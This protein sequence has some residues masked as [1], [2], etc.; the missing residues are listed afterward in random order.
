MDTLA[1][2]ADLD[3]SEFK[4][5]KLNHYPFQTCLTSHKHCALTLLKVVSNYYQDIGYYQLN[6]N[7]NKN[8]IIG[9]ACNNNKNIFM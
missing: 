5:G 9:H 3:M 6:N 2:G 7:D 4:H 1:D 8:I